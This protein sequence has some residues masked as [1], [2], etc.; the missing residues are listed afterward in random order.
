[1]EQF[2]RKKWLKAYRDSGLLEIKSHGER[3]SHKDVWIVTRQ[4]SS[5]QLLQLSRGEG[6]P[7]P[8]LLPLLCQDSV[9]SRVHLV[10]Q[11]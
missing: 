6:G 4:E 7:D 10:R 5:L 1:M 2:I 11:T 9:L 8:P 3:L